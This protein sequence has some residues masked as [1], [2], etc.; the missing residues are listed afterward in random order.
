[1]GS[2]T[3]TVSI[4]PNREAAVEWQT[5]SHQSIAAPLQCEIGS[6]GGAMNTVARWF[7][8]KA[9]GAFEIN[10]DK[11]R[12]RFVLDNGGT[13]AIELSAKIFDEWRSAAWSPHLGMVKTRTHRGE[14][15][16]ITFAGLNTVKNDASGARFETKWRDKDGVHWRYSLEAHRIK[17]PVDVLQ[18]DVALQ[19]DGGQLLYLSGPEFYPGER[20]FGREKD[21][22]I[23]PGVEY[24]D[25]DAVSSS[26]AV[27]RPPVRDQFRPHP[28]KVTIPLMALTQDNLLVSLLWP[29]KF[30][31]SRSEQTLTPTFAVP[32]RFDEQ[33]NHRFGVFAPSVPGYMLENADAAHE[34]YVIQPGETVRLQYAIY[35]DESNDPIDAID[36]WTAL[37]QR[38][39]LPQPMQPPRTYLD[40]IR[41][42]R[43]AY[44]TTCWDEDKLG[45][46]HCAG[47]AASPSGGM[48]ALLDFDRFL[49]GDDDAELS[50]RIEAVRQHILDTQG[51]AG[52]ASPSG[53]HIMIEEAAFYWGVVEQAAPGWKRNAQRLAASQNPDGSWGFHP[54][55]PE[56]EDLGED[57]EVVSG[58]IAPNAMRL[59]RYARINGDADAAQ[60]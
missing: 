14:D 38:N 29:P 47:W 36:A 16:T 25:H 43:E 18:F 6:S 58:T 31:W 5:I 45:W 1:V 28:Y 27:A 17:S 33:N 50:N 21:L 42:S 23:L 52:L 26:D 12:A 44:M 30:S 54:T 56:Q 2:V 9:P 41:V 57:G 11:W 10:G 15:N 59:L 22:A 37:Y 51:E 8:V 55:K 39:E 32:N 3:R 60:A 7:D 13:Q 20:S 35:L 48:L 53:C 24:I 40:E 34:P 4:A 46:G 49:T 19:G